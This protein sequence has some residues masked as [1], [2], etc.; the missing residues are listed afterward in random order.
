MR[1][2]FYGI[3][4]ILIMITSLAMCT[5]VF[6]KGPKTKANKIWTVLTFSVAIYGFGAF[7]VSISEN[8]Q[9]AL[10]WWQ[11]AYT[12]IILIPALFMHFICAF[13]N[14]KH[15]RFMNFIYFV[16]FA[17]WILNIIRRDLF[18]GKVSLFF[19]DSNLFKAGYWVYP[20]SP[21]LYAF[22]ILL[23]LG[24]AIIW[25]HI[26]FINEYKKTSGLKRQQFKYFFS[27]SALAFIGGATSFLPCFNIRV[28]PVLNITVALYPII[29][30]YAIIKYRLLNITVAITR[31]GVFVAVYTLVLGLPFILAT[32]GRAWIMQFF[33]INWWWVLML[34]MAALATAG[35]FIY[36]YFEK[37]AE[38]ILLREQR[39]Y[40]QTLK[41]AARELARIR[42]LKKLLSLI[43]HIVT[44]TVRICHSAIYLY[45]DKC[46][47]F[48][49]KAKRNLSGSQISALDKTS[50]LVQLIENQ[51]EPLVYEEIIKQS[52]EGSRHI[53]VQAVQQIELIN[54]ALIV[55]GF[56]KDKLLGF[57]I[58][59]NKRSGEF[60]TT[61]D[62]DTFS[63]LANQ[64]ALAAENALL[65]ENIEAQVKQRTEELLKVQKQLVQA[66]KMATV[67]TLAGGVAHEINNPLTAILTNTQ[68]LLAIR[69]TLDQDCEESLLLIEEATKRCRTIVQKLMSYAQKPQQAAQLQEIDLM[70]LVKNVTSLLEYQLNQENIK[71]TIDAISA[72]NY[73]VS[74]NP[75]ELEQVLTN[76]ILNARDAI[77]QVKQA[78]KINVSFS[79]RN[80][81]V[82]L[83]IKDDGIGIYPAAITKVF[84]PFFTTKE[85]GKGTGLG[86]AICQS[87]IEKHKGVISVQSEPDKGSTFYVELAEF[88]KRA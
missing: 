75:A 30:G 23:F 2:P 73:L 48:L 83:E 25:A 45:D 65:Y 85:V 87:I 82:K 49:L 59:G 13:L 79:K 29:M 51:R 72:E 15:F 37:R 42:N 80:G 38:S 61:E 50:P 56:L 5:F 19:S 84:D 4:N 62:L 77:R 6:L 10:F 16:T 21:V 11:I 36:I 55:P 32:Y 41:Q 20:P 43:V 33:G 47:Q 39:R 26:N 76:I 34:L 7:M 58:L 44:K 70:T 17:L 14:I 9:S 57:L 8:P 40:Q 24:V 28:Y 64:A 31:T 74:A 60:Y 66:E 46:G 68:M 1:I 22:I 63:V 35:P 81:R 67:G 27:G 78:G 3:S 18:L 54:A 12:G 86:L 71:I 52:Q 53:S 69:N 88:K